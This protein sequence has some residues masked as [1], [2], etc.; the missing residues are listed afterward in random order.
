M[1]KKVVK[2]W[3]VGQFRWRY[4]QRIRVV[5]VHQDGKIVELPRYA[6]NEV[7]MSEADPSRPTFYDLGVDQNQREPQRSSG[8]IISTG[9]GSSAWYYS[10][11]SHHC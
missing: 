11:V 6:L 1:T 5:L 3:I 7:F 9:T 8:I 4:R 10:A 2:F